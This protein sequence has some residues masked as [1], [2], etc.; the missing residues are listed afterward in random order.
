MIELPSPAVYTPWSTGTFSVSPS[1]RPLGTDFGNGAQDAHLIQ[2]DSDWERY[3]GTK[4]TSIAENRSKYV[5]IR[6]VPP[7]VI[8]AWV[9]A[10]LNDHPEIFLR[11]GSELHCAMTGET[12]DLTDPVA[13]FDALALQ[14]Q[15]DVALVHTDA[16]GADRVEAIHVCAPSRWSPASKVGRS[17]VEVHVPVPGFEPIN[18]VAGKLVEAM[19]TRG[20]FVRFVW[21]VETN[22][23][24]NHHPIAPPGFDETV[25][26]GR[27]FEEGQFFVRVERQTLLGIPEVGC[28]LFFIHVKFVPDTKILGD[29]VLL[30]SLRS[31][32][33]SMSPEA[34]AYKGFNDEF[35][36]LLKHLESKIVLEPA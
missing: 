19:V 30:N 4:L 11:S 8:E 26:N 5:V 22:N 23:H 18:R 16:T 32:L 3:H 28:A 6:N 10:L 27:L 2:F 25:W 29:A 24:L 21:T 17:F 9:S 20:P 35:D 1:L 14:I 33:A 15:P 31:A 12:I 7:Q 34:R 36:T 13:A